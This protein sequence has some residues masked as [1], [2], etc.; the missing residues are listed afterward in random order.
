MSISN[1]VITSLKEFASVPV[2]VGERQ[3]IGEDSILI[4]PVKMDELVNMYNDLYA[5]TYTT[6]RNLP[7]PPDCEPTF[8]LMWMISA[9][10]YDVNHFSVSWQ[11]TAS[12]TFVH[13][14][15][16][17]D[18]LRTTIDTTSSSWLLGSRSPVGY[19]ESMNM[20]GAAD[21]YLYTKDT[22]VAPHIDVLCESMSKVT[23]TELT[24]EYAS[25]FDFKRSMTLSRPK[26]IIDVGKMAAR[27]ARIA[28]LDE[29]QD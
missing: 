25:Y 29:D 20:A 28:S 22:I 3:N 18:R 19:T 23:R 7:N 21:V 11:G 17:I 15:S 14:W 1:S 10:N 27:N 16:I 13:M 6:W 24:R 5:F 4:S 9:E 2:Y 26:T 8:V 12:N